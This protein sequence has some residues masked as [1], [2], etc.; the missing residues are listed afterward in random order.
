LW[1]TATLGHTLH[2]GFSLG[3][4]L[5]LSFNQ[6]IGHKSKSTKLNLL[7]VSEVNSNV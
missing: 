2:R 1:S 7:T 6:S 5:G 4:G 3:F